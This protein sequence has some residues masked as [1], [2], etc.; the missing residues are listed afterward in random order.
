MIRKA[1]LAIFIFGFSSS[2]SQV[3]IHG[4]LSPRTVYCPLFA[5][6]LDS[7]ADFRFTQRSDLGIHYMNHRVESRITFRDA[8]IWQE[9][10]GALT[11]FHEAWAKINITNQLFLTAGRQEISWRNGQLLGKNDWFPL[12][13]SF[14]GLLGSYYH[15]K[16]ETSG[17]FFFNNNTQLNA[18]LSPTYNNNWLGFAGV[19]YELSNQLLINSL[20]ITD[21]FSPTGGKTQYARATAGIGFEYLWR[22]TSFHA[23]YFQQ[24]GKTSKLSENQGYSI[25]TGLSCQLKKITVCADFDAYSGSH[26]TTFGFAPLYGDQNKYFGKTTML[27]PT[28]NGMLIARLTASYPYSEQV[29]ISAHINQACEATKGC[30]FI[31][32]E[33]GIETNVRISREL[34]LQAGVSWI[35]VNGNPNS[36]KNHIFGFTGISFKMNK[37]LKDLAQFTIPSEDLQNIAIKIDSLSNLV[38]QLEDEV[39]RLRTAETEYE[40]VLVDNYFDNGNYDVIYA[41]AGNTVGV[42]SES[43]GIH[44]QKVTQVAVRANENRILPEIPAISQRPE[45]NISSPGTA[46]FVVL[47]ENEKLKSVIEHSETDLANT[48]IVVKVETTEEI[49]A[50]K[51]LKEL[52]AILK[53]AVRSSGLS[54]HIAA[55]SSRVTQSESTRPADPTQYQVATIFLA[56]SASDRIEKNLTQLVNGHYV[57]IGSSK[58]YS[59]AETMLRE[60]IRKKI[61]DAF[62][63]FHTEKNMY[64]VIESVNGDLRS[65]L[66]KVQ[67]VRSMGFHEVWIF[68]N[69]I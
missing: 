56:D 67:N 53:P 12:E 66:K 36:I 14:D 1:I 48:G 46:K 62:L 20:V 38:T 18:T 40:I 19:N 33:Y 41:D 15:N 23:S 5:T 8:R 37:N 34:Y 9:S 44:P 52:P 30:A 63:I 64:L 68:T 7:I 11:G 32:S 27:Q 57:V 43:S 22:K 55:Q 2:F 17:G 28:R 51:E 16:W 59:D 42:H 3:N 26:G 69:N 58:S 60:T 54:S 24:T 25:F 35:D 13:S 61:A 4:A 21:G 45:A 39:E 6:Q 10:K 49:N 29:D 50:A 47:T 31:G 65:A